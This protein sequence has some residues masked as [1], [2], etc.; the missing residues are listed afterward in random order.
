MG[1]MEA[2]GTAV[3]GIEGVLPA[4]DHDGGDRW[5]PVVAFGGR[6]EAHRRRRGLIVN[7]LLAGDDADP[8]ALHEAA[9]ALANADGHARSIDDAA[10]GNAAV[11]VKDPVEGLVLIAAVVGIAGFA[12]TQTADVTANGG[13]GDDRWDSQGRRRVAAIVDGDEFRPGVA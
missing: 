9:V 10:N 5:P 8:A 2:R 7:D 4:M 13:V 1:G 11:A 12:A 3:G 6:G